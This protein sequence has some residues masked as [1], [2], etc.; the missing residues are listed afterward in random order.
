MRI[1]VGHNWII[2]GSIIGSVLKALVRYLR[3]LAKAP[4]ARVAVMWHTHE[5]VWRGYLLKRFLPAAQAK[6]MR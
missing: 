1:H 5:N 2:C 6:R 3:E 4:L